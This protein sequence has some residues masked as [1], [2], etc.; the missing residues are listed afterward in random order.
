MQNPKIPILDLS[1]WGSGI[2]CTGPRISQTLWVARHLQPGSRLSRCRPHWTGRSWEKS[3]AG[4][5]KRGFFASLTS[6]TSL[7][8]RLL[9]S[10]AQRSF[11]VSSTPRLFFTLSTPWLFLTSC[12]LRLVCASAGVGIVWFW[13]SEPSTTVKLEVSEGIESSVRIDLFGLVVV[14]SGGFN[15]FSTDLGTWF[16]SLHYP[17]RRMLFQGFDNLRCWLVSPEDCQRLTF[18][19]RLEGSCRLGYAGSRYCRISRGLGDNAVS[20]CGVTG[21]DPTN[22][23]AALMV[24]AKG[25]FGAP[26]YL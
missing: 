7:S 11:L 17:A 6:L 5:R 14:D 15:G 26:T 3:Q 18:Y 1:G 13:Y 23:W 4:H 21:P 16:K 8:P 24:P 25:L 20:A 12:A 9:G 22:P 19:R 10:G 2:G